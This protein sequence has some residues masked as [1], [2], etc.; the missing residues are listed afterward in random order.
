MFN[1]WKVLA[2]S[3]VVLAN[4]YFY[5]LTGPL[6]NIEYVSDVVAHWSFMFI[7]SADLICDVF[8]WMSGFVFAFAL[9]KKQHL[10]GGTWWTHPIKLFIERIARFY[11]LYVFMH[12]F[13]WLYMGAIGGAGPRFF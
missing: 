5:I 3:M 4:T 1:A 2:I 8:Y 13:L 7:L 12:L 10:N 11:P 9:L 6:K